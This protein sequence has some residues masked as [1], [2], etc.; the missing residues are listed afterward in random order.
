[1][2]MDTD[3]ETERLQ[4]VSAGRVRFWE[5]I[6]SGDPAPAAV[7]SRQTPRAHAM[8]TRLTCGN[9]PERGFCMHAHSVRDEEAAGSNPATPTRKLQVIACLQVSVA[10]AG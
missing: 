1:M 8:S 3:T 9:V 2:V 5:R 6:G 7:R 10:G 4:R